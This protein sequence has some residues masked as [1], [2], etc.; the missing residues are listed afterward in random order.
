MKFS[1][2]F[3]VTFLLLIN[4]IVAQQPYV[5]LDTKHDHKYPV[6]V[7][8]IAPDNQTML[9]GDGGGYVYYWDLKTMQVIA[10]IKAHSNTVNSILFNTKGD[11]FVTAGDDGKAKIYD[12]K[13]RTLLQ[14][15]TAPYDRVNFAVLTPDDQTL[16]FG[17]YALYSTYQFT[18]LLKAK[19]SSPT[20]VSTVYQP[21][22]VSTNYGITDGILDYS[23]KYILFSM[24]YGV[25]IWDYK[26]DRLVDALWTG[27]YVNNITSLP[28]W[29]YG[30]CDGKIVRWKWNGT[31][32]KFD[33]MITTANTNGK[34][35]SRIVFNSDRSIFLSGD[36]SRR[37]QVY[38]TETMSLQ[39]VLAGHT[40]VVRTF[41]FWNNDSIIL[42]GGY[43]GKIKTW[44]FPKPEKDT[45][46]TIA[47]NNTEEKK[48]TVSTVQEIIE[49]KDTA[50]TVE[51]KTQEPEKPKVEYT[52]NNI[53]LQVDGRK[54]EKQG[55]FVVSQLEFEIEVWDNSVYDEDIISLNINGN[56]VL[57]N[58]EV[59]KTPHRIK[60]KI[61]P[62]TNNYL[63]LFA[64]NLG[65]IHPNTA[66]VAVIEPD[67]KRR[68]LVIKSDLGV[69]GALNFT[70]SPKTAQ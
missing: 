25:M 50:T 62:N 31:Q 54:V 63:I 28:N 38:K 23:E 4:S 1:A 61:L 32:Y 29:V 20:Q 41:Q 52:E 51:I 14:S 47:E 42:T 66:A 53:P 56:W 43:D 55:E 70:Y 34:G 10:K 2:L 40:D 21:S 26:S 22:G 57:E 15:F 30:W 60:I 36:E 67:G 27:Y 3:T 69:C 64:H 44:G 45:T 16:Y 37:V 17:G 68:R 59:T 18:G 12:F 39:Q 35:Y 9:S 48:D 6:E 58:Y 49:K 8:V 5:L 7:M 33:R 46:E 11:K 19:V 65:K 13:N 24:G